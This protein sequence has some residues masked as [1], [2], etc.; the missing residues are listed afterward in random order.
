MDP[1]TQQAPPVVA[2]VVV[3]VLFVLNPG[4]GNALF[5]SIIGAALILGILAV[6][7]IPVDQAR[8]SSNT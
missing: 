4:S 5:L 7:H 3:G 1:E 2:V 6:A 8:N